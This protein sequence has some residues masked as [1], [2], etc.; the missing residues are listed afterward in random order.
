MKKNVEISQRPLVFLWPFRPLLVR[1]DKIDG[2]NGT[3]SKGTKMTKGRSQKEEEEQ[4]NGQHLTTGIESTFDTVI[5]SVS[6]W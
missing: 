1:I 2:E 3:G 4:E 5:T 6:R